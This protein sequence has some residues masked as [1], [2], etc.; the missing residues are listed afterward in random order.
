MREARAGGRTVLLSS[1]V[2]SE[3]QEVCDRVGI[4]RDGRLVATERVEDLVHGQ[5]HRL[6]LRLE[7]V[8]PPG[9]FDTDGSREISRSDHGIVVEVRK[10]LNRVLAEAVRFGVQDVETEQV[11]LEEVFMAYYGRA[12]GSEHA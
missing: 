9:A 10:D 2:L 4:I 5:F 11:S 8:P 3:V 6:R 1:H 12:G 7:Q